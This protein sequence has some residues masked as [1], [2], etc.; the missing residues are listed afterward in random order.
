MSDSWLA[1]TWIAVIVVLG[2][3]AATVVVS[4][5]RVAGARAAGSHLEQY[6]AVT[7]AATA[8]QREVAAELARL[9]ERVAAV[10]SLLRSVG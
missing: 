1:A 7:E 2:L 10:E 8:S 9:T 4:R 6:R 5:A 3:V